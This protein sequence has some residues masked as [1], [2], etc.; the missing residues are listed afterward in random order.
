MVSPPQHRPSLPLLLDQHR[1]MHVEG[2]SEF[3]E[4][5]EIDPFG[6]SVLYGG[7]R[8]LPNSTSPAQLRLIPATLLPQ[9][10]DLDG[11]RRHRLNIR[12]GVWKFNQSP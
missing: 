2:L 4:G 3:L 10:F 5:L 7:E 12:Y 9:I 8:S 11:Y 1:R 6:L